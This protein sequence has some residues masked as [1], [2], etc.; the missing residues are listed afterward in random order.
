MAKRDN[1]A[2]PELSFLDYRILVVGWVD[3]N[4]W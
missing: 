1:L 2:V 3:E 4:A